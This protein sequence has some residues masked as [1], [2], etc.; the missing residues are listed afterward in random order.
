MFS[1]K[2]YPTLAFRPKTALM[3]YANILL[4]SPLA[5]FLFLALGYQNLFSQEGSS[6]DSAIMYPPGVPCSMQNETGLPEI[7]Y[8][9]IADDNSMRISVKSYQDS[10]LGHVHT[11]SVFSGSCNSM[12]LIATKS[13]DSLN[14]TLI[15][16]DTNAF[17]SSNLYFLKL[18]TQNGV[19]CEK[20]EKPTTVYD[21]CIGPS[22][23]LSAC[24]PLSCASSPTDSCNAVCNYNFE[25]FSPCPT[26]LDR[27]CYITGWQNPG[28]A[29]TL[30]HPTPDGFNSCNTVPPQNV[31]VPNNLFGYQF[32]IATGFTGGYG[33]FY[34]WC[35]TTSPNYREYNQGSLAAPL[36]AGKY[37]MV[38]A[39]FSLA[40]CSKFGTDKIGLYLSS[41]AIAQAD[42]F[43]PIPVVP[44]IQNSTGNFIIDKTNWVLVADTF[45]ASG[46]E[47]FIT[48]GNFYDDTQTPV[49]NAP[50]SGLCVYPQVNMAYYYV[51]SVSVEEMIFAHIVGDTVICLGE[52]T[53]LTAVVDSGGT[54]GFSYI[55][56]TGA[57][58]SS[59]T[60]T[61]PNTTTYYVTIRDTNGCKTTDSITVIVIPPPIA[62]ISGDSNN[63]FIPSVYTAVSSNPNLTYLWTASGTFSGQGTSQISM[64]SWTTTPTPF[65]CVTITDTVTTCSSQVCLYLAP[66]CSLSCSADYFN[67]TNAS[68]E[69]FT[70]LYNGGNTFVIGPLPQPLVINGTFLV[71]TDL[72]F[73]NCPEI[74]MGANAKIILKPGKKLF[75]LGGNIN[76]LQN[77]ILQAGC[78]QMW[79]GIYVDGT[80]PN[81]ELRVE[82]ATLQ[83]ALNAIVSTNGG[84]FVVEKKAI[85]NKNFKSIIV[86]P[87]NGTHPGSVTEST[88]SCLLSPDNACVTPSVDPTLLIPPHQG[89]RTAIG[90]E[91]TDVHG[92]ITVG[93]GGNSGF[94]FNNNFFNMDIGIKSLR[95]NLTAVN[96]Y[97]S[98]IQLTPNQNPIAGIWAIGD[99][100]SDPPPIYSLNAGGNLQYDPNKFDICI[101]GIRVE[102]NANA[103]II[104]NV[105]TNQGKQ[106]ILVTGC[107]GNNNIQIISN[108]LSLSRVG[109]FCTQNSDASIYI[110]INNIDNMNPLATGVQISETSSTNPFARYNVSSNKIKK[111]ETG[112][113]CDNLNAALIDNNKIDLRTPSPGPL[114]VR[115]IEL[116]ANRNTTVFLNTIKSVPSTSLIQVGGIYASISPMSKII[117]NDTRNMGYGIRCEGTMPSDIFNNSMR[118]LN[119]GFWLTSMGFVGTQDHPMI[120]GNPS[121]N[122]WIGISFAGCFTDATTIGTSSPFIYRS[123]GPAFYNTTSLT[124][125]GVAI[126]L[127]PTSSGPVVGPLCSFIVGSPLMKS[128]EQIAQDLIPFSVNDA[129]SKWI[130]KQ[131]LYYNIVF[132]N[133]NVSNNSILENFVNTCNTVPLGFL[134]QITSIG[135]NPSTNM[136]ALQNALSQNNG[137]SCSNNIEQNLKT[138]NAIVINRRLNGNNL[139]T[140][141]INTLRQIAELCPFTEGIAVYQARAILALIDSAGAAYY[142]A[143]EIDSNNFSL[144]ILGNE[145]AETDQQAFVYPNPAKDEVSIDYYFLN[146]MDGTFE[147]CDLLGKTIVTSPLGCDQNN[148]QISVEGLRPG[149]YLYKISS[150]GSL[151]QSDKLIIVR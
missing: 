76:P 142:S 14:D 45:V 17:I 85:L 92:S 50:P 73:V 66:C 91:I 9:F 79:D 41:T 120:A 29:S 46:G 35:T 74:I 11:V 42:A 133:V 102:R 108:D 112:I 1:H 100:S 127:V 81:T 48:I 114:Q 58:T 6:C 49:T 33:G 101:T 121:Y 132:D 126:P 51:D 144:K 71:D 13:A 69:F 26:V 137:I 135:S 12:S 125:G 22:L 34:A 55:W 105:F 53:V 21:L 37:Y 39:Y 116:L 94:G 122:K 109:I 115:G 24:P 134:S 130:N 38:K 43:I 67:Y 151:I 27:L 52:S 136:T 75:L 60:V 64:T 128:A 4:K 65:V 131:G 89:E 31:A 10:L 30:P 96:N 84:K 119:R 70:N 95:S 104:K 62:T 110:G 113:R 56:S 98:N 80:D 93:L 99:D 148:A 143:C 63:C 47:Q 103:N 54:P 25:L 40:D 7:W 146:K 123:P 124:G 88:I 23:L 139:N 44:Q 145:I 129:E 3:K 90:M 59:I 19:G 141:Q 36:A 117:C 97:F 18:E 87:F 2:A 78:G 140:Q 28:A 111:V 150:N 57:T 72:V 68:T 107:Q 106:C 138:V 5:L 83:D 16:I 82:N 149:V 61:P 8:M 20:C 77:T 147:I 15:I 32:D 86:H 118:F